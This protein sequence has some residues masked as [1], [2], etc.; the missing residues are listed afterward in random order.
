MMD[1]GSVK[2]HTHTHI[3]GGSV[4]KSATESANFMAES[5]DFTTD[6]VIVG[7]LSVLNMFDNLK[8]RESADGNRPTGIGRR[9]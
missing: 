1:V 6:F 3:F 8:P 2:A 4:V 7:Q 5:T 9:E